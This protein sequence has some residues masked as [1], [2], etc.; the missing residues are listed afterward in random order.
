MHMRA[1][2][3]FLQ[4]ASYVF[5]ASLVEI[6]TTLMLG[7]TVCV[8]REEDRTNG[9]IAKSMEEMGVTMTLLTPSFARVLQPADVPSLKTLILGGEA[10]GQGHVD[11]WADKLQLVNAYGPSECAVVATV[12][13]NVTRKT[14]PANLGN[15]IGRVWVVDPR[16]HHRLAPV[17]SVGELLVEGPTLSD[18]YLKNA[19]KTA[20]V[21]I[22]DPAFAHDK[23]IAFSDLKGS[24]TPRRM[25]KTGDLVRVC[26]EVTGQMVY[27][28]RKDSSQAKVNGQR[29]ELDEI[30][31]HLAG[32]KEVQHA[33]VLLPKRG[34]RAKQLVAVLSLAATKGKEG[35]GKERFELVHDKEAMKIVENVQERL[36]EKLPPFMLPST[37][38]VLQH[39][40]LQPSGKLDRGGVASFVEGLSDQQFDQLAEAPGTGLAE[41]ATQTNATTAPALATAAAPAPAIDVEAT[42]KAVWSQV[43]NIN[44]SRVGPTISFLHLGGDSITAMQVMARCRAQGVGV[45]VQDIIRCK[46]V[47]DLALKA[48]VSRGLLGGAAGGVGGQ[49]RVDEDHHEF[50]PSPIQQQYFSLV[51]D[52][53][54]A[55]GGA[56]TATQFNQSV[57]LRVTRDVGAEH[58]RK[59]LH[60]LVETHSMLRARF[61]RDGNG[62]WRQ[63][64]TDDVSGSYVFRT[65]TIGQASR[66]EKRIVQ[67]QKSLDVEKGPL[68]ASDWFKITGGDQ[69]ENVV[70]ITI[71]HLV[72]DVVSWGVIM[73]DLEDF[74]ATG[75]IKTPASM[76]FQAWSR[77]QSEQ[78]QGQKNGPGLLPHHDA[79]PADLAYWDMERK[80]NLSGDVVTED[81]ELDLDA[82]AA[83]LGP[84]CHATFET[85]ALDI[86]LACLLLSYR[87]A[88]VGREGVP[89]IHNEGHG[90]EVWDA[91]SQDLS[92]TVGWFTTLTPVHL[93]KDSKEDKSIVTAIRWVKD[94]RRRLE[95]NGRPYF[96]YRLLTA[97]GR[98]EYGHHWPVEVAFNYLGQMQQMSRTDTVLQSYD[99][100][101]GAE[102][103]IKFAS[104]DIGP[105]VPRFSLIEVSAVASGGK[106]KLSFGYNR[107]MAHPEV[108][109]KWAADCL[110]LL[111]I[112]PDRLMDKMGTEKTLAEFPL[113]PLTY[114]GID[115]VRNRLRDAVGE[116]A[117]EGG[118]KGVDMDG[119][120][121]VYPCSPL[122]RGML[123]SQ[124]R[125]PQKYGYKSVFEVTAGPGQRGGRVDAQRLAEAW[126][127]VVNRHVALRTVFVDTV[128]DEGLMTQVVLRQAPGR[129]QLLEADESA[130]TNVLDKMASINY[131]EKK[132]PHRLSIAT[133][134][135]GKVFARLDIS[136]VISDG[137]SMPVILSDLAD[138]YNNAAE[139]IA[140]PVG[141]Y[142]DY[143]AYIQAQPRSESI[144][145]WKQYLDGV[146]PCLF[147][148]LN[149]GIEV[150]P[151]DKVL[152]AHVLEVDG[153]DVRRANGYCAD[154]G[155]T[156]ATLLQFV[157]ACV[158]RAYNGSDEVLFGYLASGRDAPVPNI[159]SAVGAFI[160]MLVCRLT[161]VNETEI[162]ETLDT[163]QTNLAD[164]IAHQSSSLA[165]I[166]HEL[167]VSSTTL[168]NTAF[169]YQ[170][171][172]GV[173]AKDEAAGK[174]LVYKMLSVDDPSE[175]SVAVNVEAFDGGVEV[176][177]GYW[178][179]VVCE[180]MMRNVADTFAMV[181]KGI[182]AAER[183]DLTV[184]EVNLV[185][186]SGLDQLRGWNDVPL[187]R[188]MRLVHDVIATHAGSKPAVR[189]WDAD[190][191]Y[192]QLDAAATAL[193]RHLQDLGVGPEV[194]VPLCFEKSAWTVVAQVAVLKAGGAFVNLDPD[195]PESRLRGLVE[196]V[197]GKVVVCS[198]K[199]REKMEKIC[200]KVVVVDK[201]A[202]DAMQRQQ[203]SSAAGG[204]ALKTGVTPKNP[205][206][207]IFTS[208]TTGKPKG[209]VLEHGAFV[210]GGLAHAKA[211]F[212][213]ADSRVL[214]FASYTFDAS[215]METL[216][217]LLVGGCV[218]VPSDEDRMNDIAAAVRK[219]GV[220]WT[221]L[222]PS[223]ASTVKPESVSCLK[224]LVTG[225]EAMSKGHVQRWGTRCALVNAYGPTECAVVATTH[226]KVDEAH[227][228]LN[229]DPSNIGNAVGGR[230]WVVDAA[231]PDVLV[232]IGAVGELVV[233]GA[234]V[235][236]GYLNNEEQTRKAFITTPT[237][238]T[239]DTTFPRAMWHGDKM[240]RTGDL[241][242]YNSD[243]SVSYISRKD[244]QIKLNGR[245]I[246]L[247]EIEA[248]CRDGLPKES[249]AVVEIVEPQSGGKVTTKTLACF[250]CHAKD[251]KEKSQEAV[252]DEEGG[253][254]S[255]GLLGMSE[256][257]RAQ[258]EGMRKHVAG[259]LPTYMVP[260]LFVPV[261]AMPWTTAGKLDRRTLKKAIAETKK[262][263][264][265]QYRIASKGAP[266]AAT[267]PADEKAAEAKDKAAAT[268]PVDPEMVKTLQALWENVLQRPAGSVSANDS[269]FAIGGDSL[270]A[271]Q[272]VGAARA[273]RI[274]LSVLDIFE[275]PIL[276]DMVAACG[277][278][279]ADAVPLDLQSFDLV[280]APRS[281]IDGIVQEVSDQCLI[282]VEAIRDM[283]PCS[284]LQEGLVA[285]ASQQK[286]AYVA[287]NTFPMPE[288]MDVERLREA[289]QVVIDATDTLRTRIVHTNTA[290][291]LQVVT[292]PEPV[293]FHDEVDYEEA[294]WKGKDIGATM[295]GRLTRYAICQEEE[296]GQR[297]FI[298][299][300][301]HALY[302]GW[303]L[304]LIAR[305]VQDIY[306][307]DQAAREIV[308][309]GYAGF[310]H[311]LVNRDV[312]ASERYWTDSLRDAGAITHFPEL[313]KSLANP[314]EK[315]E[316]RT[317]FKKF[318]VKRADIKANVTVPT[319]LRA[320]WALVLAAYTGMDDV[321]FGETLSGRN[322]D[323]DGVTE[324]AGP[325]FT[326]IP[327]RVMLKRDMKISDFLQYMH[328]MA[329]R[330]VPHQHYGLQHIKSLNGDC[331]AACEFQN[332]LTIQALSRAQQD[333]IEAEAR[334]EREAD[335]D[336]QG[337]SKTEGFFT[338][339]LVLDC[340]VSD[341]VVEAVFHFNEAVVGSWGTKRMVG[342]LEGVLKTLVALSGEKEAVLGD[343]QVVSLGDLQMISSWNKTTGEELAVEDTVD[344][345]FMRQ[346]QREPKRVGITAWD[347]ELSYAEV[348]EYASRLALKLSQLGV[349]AETLVPV[350]LTRSS[351][352]VVS[353]FGVLLAGGAFVPMDPAHPVARQKDILEDIKPGLVVCSPEHAARFVGMGISGMRILSIDGAIIR[354]LPAPTNAEL[355]NLTAPETHGPSNSAYV[356]FTSGSTGKP[357]GVVVS[358][359]DFLSSSAAFA[360]ATHI[361]K[362]SR[363][364]NFA[365]LTFDVALME[366]L[367][368]LT[369]GGVVCVPDENERL[370]DLGSAM[371][372]LK[373][374]WSFLT[375]SVAN[376]LDPEA[377]KGSLKTLVCGGEALHPETVSRWADRV[378]LMNGY[379]PTEACVLA[380]VNPNVSRERDSSLIGFATP[381]GRAW[382][383]EPD[384]D[385]NERLTPVGAVGELA[386][387]GPILARGY[388][389]D[390]VKTARAFV[391]NPAW[392][393]MLPEEVAPHRIYRTGD[394][395]KY[396]RADGVIEFVGRRDGQVKVNGQR[397]ELGEIE[398][399]LVGDPNIRLALVVQ[400]KSGVCKKQLVGVV[401]LTAAGKEEV[402]KEGDNKME[403]AGD[404]TKVTPGPISGASACEP[405]TGDAE[406]MKAVKAQVAAVRNRLQDLLPH[407]MI[408]ANWIVLE[409][410]PL[411]VSGKLDRTRVVRWV[412]ALDPETWAEI[413]KS[414]GLAEEDEGDDTLVELSGTAK[415]LREIWSKELRVPVEKVKTNR[416]FVSLGGDSI[417]AMGV[418]S[419]A[420][421]AKVLLSV[422][423]VLRSKSLVQLAS[424]AR[425]SSAAAA[426]HAQDA[427]GD[428]ETE[429]PF[430]LS[431][432]Q[433][434][435]VR[436]AGKKHVGEARFNQSYALAASKRMGVKVEGNKGLR[437]AMDAIVAR[438]AMLRSRF[439]KKGDGSWE[440]RTVKMAP[441]AYRFTTHATSSQKEM[442]Q[443]MAASQAGQDIESG[444]VFSVDIFDSPDSK[445]IKI[446]MVAHH[447]CIDMVSWRIIVQDLGTFLEEGRLPAEAPL[448][449][450][451]WLALQAGHN[452]DVG[453]KRLV[454]FEVPDTD[455]GYWG[456]GRNEAQTYGHTTTA[457][458]DLSE[459]VTH[460]ALGD[461]HKAF[462]SEPLDLFLAAIAHSFAIT[463]KRA[464]PPTLHFE[465]HGREPPAGSSEV[466]LSQTIG[467]FTAVCPLVV[468]VGEGD[469]VLDTVRRA[470][471]VRRSIPANGRSWFAQK[472]LG[473]G[474]SGGGIMEVLFNYL[475]GGVA[476]KKDESAAAEGAVEVEDDSLIRAVDLHDGGDEASAR[477]TADVGLETKRLALFEI[478]AIVTDNKLH[479]SFMYD[480]RLKRAADVRTWIGA[481]QATL[482]QMV[483]NL[484]YHAAEPTL[485]DY[486]LLPLNYDNLRRLVDISLPKA[487]VLEPLEHVED[488]YP[489]GPVQEGMLISQLR[490]PSAYVFHAVY[491]VR[492]TR[493]RDVMPDAKRMARAWQRTVDKHGALRTVFIESVHRGSI[494]D[495]IVLKSIDAGAVIVTARDEAEAMEVL[496]GVTIH[497]QP[498]ATADKSSD[499]PK[500]PKL[501]H[502]LGICTT[503]DGKMI[504]KLEINH[505]AIDGG[506]LSIVL[507]ELATAYMGTMTSDPGPRYSDYIQYIR[508]R[509]AQ[510]DTKYWMRYLGGLQPCYFPKLVTDPAVKKELKMFV[511]PFDRY[512]DLRTLSE[513]THVTLANMMHVAWA[514]VLRK[515]TGS[516][517][518]CFGYLTAGRDAPVE[519]L[520][521]TIGCFINMLC[522]RIQISGQKQTLE[523]VFQKAQ[524][525]HLQSLPFQGCSLARVQH[526]LGLAGNRSLYNTS[527]STQN[528][529][530][531][532]ARIEEAQSGEAE[533]E[534]VVFE[535]EAGYDPS[536]YV[537]TVNVESAK[538]DEGV[539]FRYW[540]DHVS[541]EHM[542]E[543]SELMIKALNG[544]I[545]RA[546][547]TIGEFDG[548]VPEEKIEQVEETKAEE[549]KKEQVGLDEK[550]V[551][552]RAMAHA[553]EIPVAS[554]T[555]ELSARF[556][557]ILSTDASAVPS[558]S[559]TSSTRT[560]TSR[561]SLDGSR[562]TSSRP[563]ISKRAS[564]TQINDEVALREKNTLRELWATLLSIDLG[565]TTIGGG[566]SFFDLGGDSIIAMKLVGD[567]RDRGL[568]LTVAAVFQHPR[569]DDQA[570]AIRAARIHAAM[571]IAD[572][573][574]EEAT[575]QALQQ[576]SANTNGQQDTAAPE[577]FSLLAASNV[578]R[579]LQSSIIPHVG[580]FKGGLADVLPAT[581]FQ[582]LAI[583]GSMLESRWMLN[584]FYLDGEGLLNLGQLKRA[585][586]RL[587]Q[588]L[589]I[590]RTVFV[591]SGNRFLQVVLRTLRPAFKVFELEE[592]EDMDEFTG[593]LQ[594]G[595]L[596]S[597]S[598]GTGQGNRPGPGE[599]FV[600]FTV[601]RQGGRHRILL[602]LSHA[603]YVGVCL[604][605]ILHA[606]QAAYKGQGI[607]RPVSFA[608]Y[609]R[610]SA[611]SLTS[612]HYQH[613]KRLLEGSEMT[614][615]V[616]RDGPSYKRST[617]G[618]TT[619]LKK[620]V[621]L[622]PVA[623]SGGASITTATVV[624][625]AWAYVLAQVSA[626]HDVVFGHTIS[627]RNAEVKGIENMIGPCLNLVPVRVTFGGDSTS[628]S[629]G[630]T[631][632]PWTATDLLRYIQDQQVDN[633]AHEIL[634]FREIIRHCT[635]W[636]DWTYFT[637]TVQHQ[638]IDQSASV[639]LGDVEYKVGW[640][641]G[642]QEDFA[643]LSVFSQLAGQWADSA[644]ANGANGEHNGS[645][646]NGKEAQ[647]Q[648][649][650]EVMLSFTEGGAIPHDF[651]EKALDMLAEAAELFASTPDAKLPS[652]EELCAREPMVPFEEV[653]V[654]EGAP[655]TNGHNGRARGN[656]GGRVNANGRSTQ[657]FDLENLESEDE[658]IFREVK[659]GVSNDTKLQRLDRAQQMGLE[660]VVRTAW[661]QVLVLTDQTAKDPFPN[662]H[663]GNG[664]N[665]H[666]SPSSAGVGG[667]PGMAP[668]QS[669][670]TQSIRSLRRPSISG[671]RA[672]I[673]SAAEKMN[674]APDANFFS[675]GG[676]II[677]LAQLCWLL[678]QRGFPVPRI[679][680]LIAQPTVRGHMGVL[681]AASQGW[682]PFAA[683]VVN[684]SVPEEA[685]E[686]GA[687]GE[688][689]DAA[690]EVVEGHRGKSGLPFTRSAVKLAKRLGK[691]RSEVFGGRKTPRSETF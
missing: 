689:R 337:G 491:Q 383:V 538:L 369:M 77:S 261:K 181:L 40:P 258:A 563:A 17:G 440:Q 544:F 242:R 360:A 185:G 92:R 220:T 236:R 35:Q 480:N 650:Y 527:I 492:Y 669:S 514:L 46:N 436:G 18:G 451:A 500:G 153:E 129:V 547:M 217:C 659:A 612:N 114:Y 502:R 28:G 370:R 489:C 111:Q 20:E 517:D 179:H 204:M 398:N 331:A 174:A 447:L 34:S 437:A 229:T 468:A 671:R 499:K 427:R 520:R 100:D 385:K 561:S 166:Q 556:G 501:P 317:E 467:W 190:F 285:L 10:M 598:T 243:G 152:A 622:P 186:Q 342:Q 272:L 458:F 235:A 68:V 347:A 75:A 296:G 584:Y 298:W 533:E 63:R 589:D 426:Q 11:T 196:D 472:W 372:S 198:P 633:M 645:A 51:G 421:N 162:G 76:S 311:Y 31:H 377:V 27:M 262:E 108:V 591:P 123:L 450:K 521:E 167:G 113:L 511:L 594:R 585:C 632:K 319:L 453:T 83:L 507:E 623:V 70:F 679:E 43:L 567:A 457:D 41:P 89:T 619:T 455:L 509:P 65:H 24:K 143:M 663:H 579:F 69:E 26:D 411:V 396:R 652:A 554:P 315:P 345:M 653:P 588:S 454:P 221:L 593:R 128:G 270:T 600:E 463:F 115:N 626:H 691:K 672:S 9:N 574:E 184:G 194:F 37:F 380:V 158:V 490:D 57:L 290:G 569:F 557:G 364:F 649:M 178:K 5:D 390:P 657:M 443:I 277:G 147:P 14:N 91:A 215:I 60:A 515:Y 441:T 295:G 550:S 388:L 340:H 241:V 94:F 109:K 374:T 415:I 473:A 3:R 607:I 581:D 505:I 289:W 98:K 387:S 61:R 201:K 540:T 99:S 640:V 644:G 375:P 420:R 228:T 73:Q 233:E 142:R 157:W 191:S 84:E 484:A 417:T 431:P 352:A 155:I 470:K 117:S 401:N 668:R 265:A 418:V 362:D 299:A 124:I 346:A 429:E 627:G 249:Q 101:E 456:V 564:V 173:A 48:S 88:A 104:S 373:A 12:N 435:Y 528:H 434:M 534:N 52:G 651:A 302:D 209:T 148:T 206:Y 127:T 294:V 616:R 576:V 254:V 141:L 406:K 617:A 462:R 163:M 216:S 110:A 134:S 642:A 199:W 230:V 621:H 250:F 687:E 486:P 305:Q 433:T 562:S 620:L 685:V 125:D 50:D 624:K 667:R 284:P 146:E 395:V 159:E 555:S 479:F 402:K 132:P 358:H 493:Q 477:A 62:S 618:R 648:D 512:D 371:S 268:A 496:K 677:G 4:F 400:P 200:A 603:E 419:R 282:P 122:Q 688:L 560:Q 613:W 226:T 384:P 120:E 297:H 320:A 131:N 56:G 271:M 662:M 140:K 239:K 67:S 187:P 552:A 448:S 321:V 354:D 389:N 195:H 541:E 647:K 471:D 177:F 476:A 664:S 329:S 107:H 587:V 676:D 47:H 439:T 365:S 542:R 366:V 278:L 264:I 240:Y 189:G 482:E 135:S 334:G 313:P 678:E 610:A 259:I 350:C 639:R 2:F 666:L 681:A 78:A 510:A 13:P 119:V 577:R 680:D 288:D 308:R 245:R 646:G 344:A 172:R 494:F 116:L 397:L 281:E 44:P 72:I 193:A 332:L 475:G 15:G 487:G 208:G 483:N 42:L 247:G 508:N 130:V 39:I 628:T 675:L 404:K 452:S 611:G 637:S 551:A 530:D 16:N 410:M 314:D 573:D 641:A 255:F 8:P 504:V 459:K 292:A 136:H 7:G 29:L 386:L 257:L 301:H 684:S 412:E 192:A 393:E 210:T 361:R 175:Y 670:Y 283:Y 368:P 291:F 80:P 399:R 205:A 252:V 363:C 154:Q 126:Q 202:M 673:A 609:L 74:F 449:F 558:S 293:V 160:N 102:G 392:A 444:P 45:T 597:S 238:W 188:E 536:E 543:M 66:M 578:D 614:E 218:C 518:V 481:C 96:A 137:S 170:F 58:F 403:A 30:A 446:F 90:R 526:E 351:W 430:A 59:A 638:N 465:G 251:K 546:G 682:S 643:D 286:G 275:K 138:A 212:M 686:D 661:R 234:L 596:S 571:G 25:Y 85:E 378:E 595:E 338:H 322:I 539:V 503:A 559:D 485:S 655:A 423:D 572:G 382:I 660:D 495:Q 631:T 376:L 634:G 464:Q 442:A 469:D 532:M 180:R 327:T 81:I 601:L 604:P 36:R 565:E 203:Q 280:Q 263:D 323:L 519:N 336:W 466:D 303:S 341:K 474:A 306:N 606:L 300:I 144:R 183:D 615:I 23:D 658:V 149:D 112:A 105:T 276:S 232:P 145:Y 213:H 335:W 683:G 529:G 256:E 590:L 498:G 570:A 82:T 248:N 537:I 523:D 32:D 133:T 312:A 309:P 460:L 580:V 139:V 355:Q 531:S 488:I 428:E 168:F 54:G 357:K 506:S 326:T 586:F 244:T 497:E 349:K 246:E 164:A 414:L 408:P 214:Q 310:V 549:V 71:H 55:P 279:E 461:A 266:K 106:M 339:P 231:R 513:T 416:G 21:F 150:R 151:E 636:D 535:M 165:E 522:C 575:N 237:R 635:A 53:S 227:R 1:P 413:Q 6:L 568:A 391:E 605:K 19:S 169:T 49:K 22:A 33:L 287:V 267:A 176:H 356:L 629:P 197:S 325:V 353:L 516:D 343:V 97:Q 381:A 656:F 304:P 269:F 654:P 592:E 93:P 545:D 333:E 409:T 182:V 273:R 524:D 318:Y 478:S 432:I 118:E 324:M 211:M 424:V 38:L 425:V 161:L 330:V 307:G 207:V 219:M 599:P 367:T 171:R 525:Q 583:T 86:L 394:L 222:T 121:D 407:Y 225:G 566:D 253:G 103:A 64:I 379:G 260:Q 582:S 224:T 548:V 348:R 359:R 445:E 95:G 690:A 79:A 630:K 156:L 553:H 602:R 405:V 274:M 422:Q 625:A 316:Y 674:L 438:H 665:S 223:V 608:N 87:S 328:Q